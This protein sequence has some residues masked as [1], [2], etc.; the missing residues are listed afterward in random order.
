MADDGDTVWLPILPSFRDFAGALSRGTAGAGERAGRAVGEGI[1]DGVASSRA[2]VEKASALVAKATDRVADATGKQT[3]AQAKLQEMQQNGITRGGRYAAALENVARANRGVEA[4][5]RAAR[6]ATD[7][8][9]AAES[10]AA[11]ATD[12]LNDSAERTGGGLKGMF[13]G[14]GG[15]IKQLAA[16]SAGAAGFGGVMAGVNKAMSNQADFSQLAAAQGASSELAKEYGATAGKLYASGVGESMADVTSAIDAAQSSFATL[17]YEGEASLEQVTTRAVNF[18]KT[19]GTDVDGAIQTAAQLVQNG[20]AVDSTQAFDLMTTSFQ[21]VPK[22]MREELPEI[23]QEYGTNFRALGFEG[24][25]AFNVLVSA[26]QNGK[27]ALDKTGDAL[28]EFT[29][30][31]S[32]MSKSSVEAY[33][34]IGLNATEMS[35][36]VATGGA[37]AQAAL[38]QTAQG[39]LAIE[40]PSARAN[41]A[42]ALFGAP[43][44][45]LSVD[46]IPSFLSG[47]TGAENAMAG[48]EGSTDAMGTTL[49]DNVLSKIDTFKRGIEQNF[50]NLLGEEA[51]PMI[52]DFTTALDENEGSLL[53][54]VA[55]MTGLGGAVAGFETAKGVFD[56]VG[57][58]IGSVKDGIASVKETYSSAVESVKSGATAVKDGFSAAKTAVSGAATQARAAATAVASTTAAIASNTAAWAANGLAA[59]RAA[60]SY[61]AQK[62]ALVAS[63][64]ATAAA[65]AGQ[66]LLNVAMSANPIGLII[67]AVAALV[68]GLVWFF[69]QTELGQKIVTAAWDAIRAGWDYMWNLVSAGI[70]A[71]GNAIGWIG[72]K[73]GEAKDWVVGKFEELVGFVTALPGRISSAA[74]GLWDGIKNSFRSAINWLISAWNNFSLGFD[75]KIPVINKQVTFRIDT[76]NLPLLAGGGTIASRDRD[77]VLSGPGTATSDSI[78]GVD[79]R[80]IP[81][82]RVADGEGVVKTSAMANGGA[83]LVK[84]LNAGWVP[85][86]DL[87]RA[88]YGGTELARGNY[89]GSLSA[90]GLEEDNPLIGAVLDAQ[91]FAAGASDLANKGDFNGNLSAFGIEEDNPLVAAVL[92]GRKLLGLSGGG[93]ITADDLNRFPRENG[94]E[95]AD[96]DWGGVNWGDCSGAMSALANFATGRDPFGSRFAT[97]NMAEELAARGFQP[98]LG[99][100]GSFNLGWYNGGPYGGH[101][102]GT[103]PDG[104][105]VE[106]GG[107]RGNGQVGGG[108]VGADWSEFT[109]HAHLPPEFFLGGDALPGATLDEATGTSEPMPADLASASSGASAPDSLSAATPPSTSAAT[110]SSA[111]AS[112]TSSGASS[113]S[114]SEYAGQT[115]SDFASGTVKDTLDFF[116]LGKLADLP[117]IPVSQPSPELT[118]PMTDAQGPEGQAPLPPA[119][120]GPLIQFGDVTTFDIEEFI[121]MLR[122]EANHL[123][124]SDSASVGGWSS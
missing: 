120:P 18:G 48:F 103:L 45:D 70:T 11:N 112:S 73:A 92:D 42:I 81:L 75:F 32:D 82:V 53:G 8:L 55:G 13:S 7:Q 64:V 90:L 44:E 111:S 24:P 121:K 31:G 93:L 14:M 20:L 1:A 47:L 5:N 77:G 115:A 99:P 113:M 66:W 38:Q 10:R 88:M 123:V 119:Q 110:A 114:L 39:L 16:L 36:A 37:G 17:G 57:E 89:T 83:E 107:G 25:A 41:A 116:G 79:A 4:A 33:E 54:A 122:T 63:T 49:N 80:G 34:L 12:D 59:G 21:R 26:A 96:Y 124:R 117:I 50:V 19:F 3:V 40:D 65:T 118:A 61:L 78:L 15:G 100:A 69:T 86:A 84:M 29:I 58:G 68:A 98:G 62:V 105:N 94:L 6:T 52:G 97:G 9:A 46:Q 51:L 28:K 72:E 85:P 60:A 108:A 101:T 43:L 87:L 56:S 35:N 91:R 30:L 102:A 109:D 22:A 2:A 23:L 74:S 76:P 71:F 95:G 67:A 106:M 104:T 27:F